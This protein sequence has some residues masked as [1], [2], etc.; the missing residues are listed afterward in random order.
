MTPK[1]AEFAR[2]LQEV[3]RAEAEEHLRAIAAGL[4]E[5]ENPVSPERSNE[6]LEAIYRGAHSLKG[7]AR[8]VS[9]LE[10][11]DLCHALESL[12]AALQRGRL[13]LSPDM[14]D[15][16]HNAVDALSEV[17][18]AG[19]SPAPGA[20]R[21]E[22]A[23]LAERV[24][25]LASPAAVLE[26]APSQRPPPPPPQLPP[27][28][29]APASAE[30]PPGAA[31]L[32]RPAGETVRIPVSRLTA[33][34]LEAE[35]FRASKL[36][37]GERAAQLGELAAGLRGWMKRRSSLDSDLRSLRRFVDRT[38]D[39]EPA[40][41]PPRSAMERLLN[42]LEDGDRALS[43]LEER[44]AG[45]A[46]AA[47][48]DQRALGS[49]VDALLEQMKQAAMLPVSS[50]LEPF[51]KLARD[52]ARDRSKRIQFTIAGG[53]IEADRRILEE[54]KT[55]LIHL[56]RNAID[57][58]VEDPDERVRNGK[59]PAARVTISVSAL[60]GGKFRIAITDDGRGID[61]AAA[62]QAAV[63]LGIV[64]AGDAEACDE[65]AILDL[66]FR[67]GL[68]TTPRISDLSGRGLG[69]AIVRDKVE[70]LGGSIAVTNRPGAGAAFEIELPLSL[71]GFRGVL[72]RTG[73][74]TFVAPTTQVERV[75][76]V[77]PRQVESV[78]NRP[79]LT[80]E[81][82]PV[83][84]VRLAD[85]LGLPADEPPNGDGDRKLP[86]VVLRA[87]ERRIACFVDEVVEEQELL[88]K[89]I[90]RGVAQVRSI[91]GATVL[92]SGKVV[93]ILNVS[94]LISFATQAGAG[95][96][97]PREGPSKKP[98][99]RPSVLLVEDSITARTLLKNIL[100]AAGY[101][102]TTAVDGMD[103]FSTLKSD[104]FDVV[105]SDVEMPR[106][107]GV[108]L[109]AK[110]RGDQKLAE[111]PVVLVSALET[112]EHRERGM[113]AGANA[114]IGK[115]SF[116]HSNLLEVIRRLI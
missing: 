104:R 91:A 42:H 107:D 30:R 62:K 66:I 24:R 23:A 5:L 63:R 83:G 27:L 84:V 72:L 61:P 115:S 51:P 86:A 77:T 108:E 70:R 22:V 116:D 68:T 98:E 82:Q 48:E 105:V 112:R 47:R 57:H 75:L 88:R 85:L 81:G 39:Q 76:R 53:E 15:L 13:A 54:L 65:P 41:E 32:S 12:F 96:A 44:L 17:V 102:V 4:A 6:L 21:P 8:A 1:D 25:E 19:V 87:G 80:L 109:T 97:A 78:E 110:I 11:E 9:L 16:L 40:G 93:P 60:N 59:P 94:E 3:F 52:L 106:M 29:Q 33:L 37:A 35:E 45:V 2:R 67:S 46:R 26:P 89:S 95:P 113:E 73:R 99:R 103:A 18:A 36:A 111:L 69:L 101:R 71:A 49:M 43:A 55:P 20:R 31:E 74:L 50:L 114:Y 92:A 14:L 58:G 56:V 64:S 79:V 100:E 7:A 28:A 38:D 90:G 34:L 10:A